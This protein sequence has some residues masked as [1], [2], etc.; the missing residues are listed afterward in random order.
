MEN[1]LGFRKFLKDTEHRTVVLTGISGLFLLIS[2]LGW[3]K[4]VLPFDAAWFSIAISGIPLFHSA[5]KKL[6]T[7]FDITAGVLICIALIAAVVIGEYFAAGEVAFIMMIGELLENRTVRKAQEGIKKLMRL[8]PPMARI[9]KESGEV[10]IPASEVKIGDILL[11]KPGEAIPAD[12]VIISGKSTVDQ[13]I[14]TGES[15]PVDKG[16][17]DEVFVGTVNQLGVIELKAT[18][19]GE[20]TS[21]AKL[22]R[23]VREAEQKKAPVVRLADRLA[24][25]IV[26]LALILSIVVYLITRDLTRAVTVLVVFCP[27]ALVLATPTAIMAGIGNA[28]KKGILI[29]SG[30]A[31]EATG[32]IDTIAFDKTG[33]ITHGRPEVVDVISFDPNHTQESVLQMAATAEK[34]SEHPIGKAIY[35][36]AKTLSFTV[37]DPEDFQILLGQG[38]VSKVDGNRILVGNTK[39]FQSHNLEI[40]QEYIDH[41]SSYECQGKTTMIV[42]IGNSV[43]GMIAVADKIKSQATD[44]I[45]QL[46]NIG[47]HNLMLLTG[48]NHNAAHAIAGKV[49]IEKVH[50]RQIPEEKVVVLECEIKNNKKVCMIGD[51]INDAPALAVSHIGIAMGALGTDV[52]VETADIAL[53]SDDLSKIPELVLLARKVLMTIKINIFLSMVINFGAI[54]LAAVGLLNPISGA[55]VHNLGSVLVVMNSATLIKYRVAAP[56]FRPV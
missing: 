48:D 1:S 21:L 36:K 40:P 18:K 39:L 6:V 20:D 19:V 45:N 14:I 17:G 2:W 23:L 41:I 49:G 33:T 42:A 32:T 43:I 8:T 35:N 12:G 4:G 29:K 34:F 54:F 15:M 46:K 37:D 13:S 44:T 52:A 53:M 31:L 10:D 22:I 16:T 24:A 47:I 5:I 26:P 50:A 56:T 25:I 9:R 28:A 51:G 11:V 30:A 27:C 3:L 38:V 55:L 7:E